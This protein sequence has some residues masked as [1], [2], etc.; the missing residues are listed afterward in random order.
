[1][2]FFSASYDISARCDYRCIYCR[3]DWSDPQN[4]VDADFANVQK[5]LSEFKERG[6]KRVVFT[7]GEFFIYPHWR[8]AL[9]YNS[10]LG[11]ENWIISG[12]P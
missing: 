1:M 11:M 10:S 4:D 7:G 2:T 6:F 8:D 9:A 12:M 5:K 3:N